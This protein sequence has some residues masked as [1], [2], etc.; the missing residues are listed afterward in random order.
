MGQTLQERGLNQR[1]FM[2]PWGLQSLRGFVQNRGRAVDP[3]V[4]PVFAFFFL[5]HF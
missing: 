1:G 2:T 4:G 3:T 5:L